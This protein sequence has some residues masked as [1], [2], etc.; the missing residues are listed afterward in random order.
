[1]N[2]RL[3]QLRAELEKGEHKLRLIDRER[4]E[5]RDTMLRISGA[6]R[7]L[8]ELL[9]ESSQQSSVAEGPFA[10]VA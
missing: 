4:Q 5:V 1:M 9:E 6:I 7:V 2:E 8:E 10:R 3:A